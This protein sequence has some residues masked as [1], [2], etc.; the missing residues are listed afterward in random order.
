[1]MDTTITCVDGARGLTP[2]MLRGPNR[3]WSN[4][5]GIPVQYRIDVP[6]GHWYGVN[7]QMMYFGLTDNSHNSQD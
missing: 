6:Y 3:G 7:R 5:D 2:D 1:M 4:L